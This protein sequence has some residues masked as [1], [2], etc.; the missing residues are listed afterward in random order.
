MEIT[1]LDTDNSCRVCLTSGNENLVSL[2]DPDE[3]PQ[4]F[5]VLKIIAS[6]KIVLNDSLSQKICLDCRTKAIDAHSFRAMCLDS[7][8]SVRYHI[9]LQQTQDEEDNVIFEAEEEEQCMEFDSRYVMKDF[10]IDP[11]AIVENEGD[12]LDQYE[13]LMVKSEIDQETNTQTF[14]ELVQEVIDEE[15]DASIESDSANDTAGIQIRSSNQKFVIKVDANDEF[16]ADG[17]PLD[18]ITQRMREA[19]FAKEQ[20]KKYKCDFCDKYFMFPSKGKCY[21]SKTINQ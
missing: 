12:E 1:Y 10:K 6:V 14:V 19:H 3:D 15:D 4:L 21:W 18:E 2:F 9:A 8:E 5:E 16:V 13:E 7:D 11:D 20:Q 17:E